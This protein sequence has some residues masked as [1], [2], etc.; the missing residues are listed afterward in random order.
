MF[1]K[2]SVLSKSRT[3]PIRMQNRMKNNLV[4]GLTEEINRMVTDERVCESFNKLDNITDE[5]ALYEGE[6]AW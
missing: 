3:A 5:C 4:D 1:G 2:L 6:T